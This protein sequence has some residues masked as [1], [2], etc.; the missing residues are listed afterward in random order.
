M[1]RST[2]T[3]ISL[4]GTAVVALG[5]VVNFTGA[6][7]VK[8]W[9][10]P[11]GVQYTGS[12]EYYD[13]LYGTAE[14]NID[15][16]ID[17]TVDVTNQTPE[18]VDQAP[19]VAEQTPEASDQ[20]PEATDQAP[21]AADQTAEVT[22]QAQETPAQTQEAS[23]QTSEVV[24]A[25]SQPSPEEIQQER[26]NAQ[27]AADRQA[28]MREG[29]KAENLS[30]RNSDGTVSTT[31]IQGVY[32]VNDI[33][34]IAFQPVGGHDTSFFCVAYETNASKSPAAI[35]VATEVANSVNAVVGPSVNIQYE[36]FQGG[37][38]V[39]NSEAAEG[40]MKMGLDPA[41]AGEGDKV[42]VVAVYPGGA[43]KIFEDTDNDPA[44]VTVDIPAT[45]SS[46]V[47]YTLIKYN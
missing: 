9:T 31:T 8:A 25:D 6:D 12:R 43:T 1:R 21:E 45:D 14:E 41:F 13:L 37:N 5:V 26:I 29:M 32:L 46:L 34:G 27:A 23:A 18:A 15:T 40:T 20:A 33:K 2:K 3:L 39:K 17:Q 28:L 38:L 44:T 36:K 4:I 19:Q 11:D 16:T 10:G 42:G 22:N 35:A 47:M 24:Q 7:M 30:V